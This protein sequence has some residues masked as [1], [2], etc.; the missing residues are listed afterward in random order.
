MFFP[1]NEHVA[2]IARVPY[3]RI[4]TYKA[5]DNPVL[6]D[7]EKRRLYAAYT[8]PRLHARMDFYPGARGFGR[9]ARD[10][11]L[12]PWLCSNSVDM[13]VVEDKKRN[14]AEYLGDDFGLFKQMFNIIGMEGSHTK[15]FPDGIWLLFD[16]SPLNAV[17]SGAKHVLMPRR[18]WNTSDWGRGVL[19]PVRDKVLYY[20]GPEEACGM[21]LE[22][23]DA[24][25]GPP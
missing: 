17:A 5:M 18:P 7:A 25:L 24:E 2:R 22:L 1:L 16:D 8:A 19:A 3:G 10:P 4:V 13:D 14:L 15:K 6:S 21:A 9:L 12:D 11:R 23:M 20:E